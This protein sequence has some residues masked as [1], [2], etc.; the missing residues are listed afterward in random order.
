MVRDLST[1]TPWSFTVSDRGTIE[2]ATLMWEMFDHLLLHLL[3]QAI[4][5]VT[6]SNNYTCFGF[7]QLSD[8]NVLYMFST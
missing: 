6:K 7:V 2:P 8:R 4:G 3:Q 1:V 5:V